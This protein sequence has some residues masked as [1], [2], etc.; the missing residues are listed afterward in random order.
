MTTALYLEQL[1]IW[2][3]WPSV[4]GEIAPN[5]PTGQ[6]TPDCDFS[7]TPASRQ[8][9][10]D[11]AVQAI[12]KVAQNHQR[13]AVLVSGGL[14][15][16]AVLSILRDIIPPERILA[17]TT[18][19]VDDVGTP[20]SRFVNE[21]VRTVDPKI[22]IA[23]IS[24]PHHGPEGWSLAAPRLDAFPKG[25]DA[26]LIKA[27]DLGCTVAMTGNG[28]DELFGTPRFLSESLAATDYR[29]FLSYMG[30]TVL[31][32]WEAVALEPLAFGLNKLPRRFHLGAYTRLMCRD[33]YHTPSSL[34]SEPYR[35][36][37]KNWTNQ[38][39]KRVLTELS[40]L[41]SWSEFD[42]WVNL[43]P[44]KRNISYVPGINLEHPLL[45]PI[46]IS[47]ALQVP[48][49]KRYEPRLQHPYW[50]AKSGVLSLM[51]PRLLKVI[52]QHKQI[53]S[54]TFANEEKNISAPI[55]T[56][57]GLI[58]HESA[59]D[60]ASINMRARIQC[61]EKWLD[62]VM[63]TEPTVYDFSAPHQGYIQ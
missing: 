50:R 53:F 16:A 22:E 30:D 39:N 25:N 26:M 47:A 31:H 48:L 44:I 24:S 36:A 33:D 19:L 62:R 5:S 38:W 35:E 63:A 52:P 56:E 10:A 2:L 51:S 59:I 1:A 29:S 61:L 12:E 17:V 45:D 32:S 43:F 34:I 46:V 15:S 4:H 14:D 41:H 18:T 49:G 57:I 21:I 7:V 8:T 37:V 3:A 58:K 20:S 54:A 42:A 6:A 28:G 13:I 40:K 55:L 27:R 23:T 9:P 60:Q 11:A